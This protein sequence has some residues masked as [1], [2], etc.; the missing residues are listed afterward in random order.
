MAKKI[1]KNKKFPNI[2]LSEVRPPKIVVNY[3]VRI[4][5]GQVIYLDNFSKKDIESYAEQVKNSIIDKF[6]R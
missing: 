4:S 3:A 1:K 2:K 5:D 6:I